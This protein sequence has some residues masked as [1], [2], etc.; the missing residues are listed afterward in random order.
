MKTARLLFLVSL[1]AC[2]NKAAP[3]DQAPAQPAPA[4]PAPAPNTHPPGA[5]APAPPASPPNAGGLTWSEAAPLVR[6]TPKSSMRAAEYGVSGDDRAEL[7]VFYFG[8]DQGGSVESN[9]S[10]WLGQITQPDG[11]ASASK[12]KRSTREVGGIT[13]ALVEVAGNYTGGMAM[14]GAPAPVPQADAL[15]L[16]AIASGP[17]GPVFFKFVGA[18]AV[19]ERSRAAFDQMIGSLHVR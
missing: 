4:Q 13:V 3:A 17:S 19:I 11:T 1:V 5:A 14:P 16:G 15:L 2:G 10:R 18:R 6:R 12:A 9:V 8:P 7:A